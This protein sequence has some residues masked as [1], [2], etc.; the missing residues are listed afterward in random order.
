MGS[1][2]SI[3]YVRT[4]KAPAP[5]ALQRETETILAELDQQLSN[6]RSDSVIQAFNALPAGSCLKVPALMLR[7]VQAGEQLSVESQGALDLTVQPLLELWGFG[8]KHD[9]RIPSETEIAE[10]RQ[11]VGHE[12]LHIRGEE[13]C[14]DVA[15]KLDFNSIAAGYAV[16]A[17][18]ARLES[19]GVT[20]YLVE[21]TGELKA[22]GV[23]PDG[24]AWRIA[25]E[26]PKD[27]EREAMEVI[28]LDGY[29]ISTSGD[30]RNYFEKDGRRYS[31]TLDPQLG[32]PIQHRLAAVTVAD[33][34]AMRADGLSTVLMVMG[35]E[36]G[37]AFAHQHKIAALFVSRTEKGFVSESTE[38]FD[39]LFGKERQP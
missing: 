1:T 22:R 8:P 20:R 33:P 30:Y 19:L 36:K 14:K 35:P 9:Q 3:K 21:I 25:I 31:H 11:R 28:R 10:A 32:A 7:L 26:A 29:S 6:Y 15:L 13:L 34:S 39:R 5:A 2:Y 17:V 23:K 12:H 27:D 18:S 24:S 4:P 37:L 16:D 38:S